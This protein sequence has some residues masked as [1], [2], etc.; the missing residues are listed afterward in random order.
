MGALCQA[1]KTLHTYKNIYPK[2]GCKAY[3]IS[4]S[5]IFEFIIA[6]HTLKIQNPGWN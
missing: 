6:A 5:R 1:I 4:S 3:K 2:N